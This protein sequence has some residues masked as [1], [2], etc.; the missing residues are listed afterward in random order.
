MIRSNSCR[1]VPR[2]WPSK[3]PNPVWYSRFGCQVAN[4]I[5]SGEPGKNCDS[6]RATLGG[7]TWRST[8]RSHT[9]LYF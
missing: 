5:H 7:N 4:Q 3:L 1:F 8:I 2:A 9:R 6:V